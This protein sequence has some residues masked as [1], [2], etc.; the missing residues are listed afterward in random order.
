M[1]T[2]SGKLWNPGKVPDSEKG[3]RNPGKLQN[4]TNIPEKIS[5][6]CLFKQ[7]TMMI[8]NCSSQNEFS[9]VNINEEE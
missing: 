8:K 7:E 6:Q 3:A 9:I 4:Y 1:S 5:T 2:G